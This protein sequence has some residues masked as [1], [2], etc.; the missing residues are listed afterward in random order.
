M[1]VCVHKKGN[2]LHKACWGTC[3]IRKE[4]EK[5]ALFFIIGKCCNVV[6]VR[7]KVRALARTIFTVQKFKKIG[8]DIRMLMVYSVASK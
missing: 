7:H 2:E 3:A 6:I 5:I 4:R 1:D 8:V